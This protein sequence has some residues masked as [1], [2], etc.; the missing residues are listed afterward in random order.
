MVNS[1]T[2]S[3]LYLTGGNDANDKKR[4]GEWCQFRSSAL[5]HMLCRDPAVGRGGGAVA[6]GG[7]DAA[8]QAGPRRPRHPGHSAQ[9]LLQQL[10]RQNSLETHRTNISGLISVSK[11]NLLKFY[12]E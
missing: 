4:R 2:T 5:C 6:A 7:G 3:G 9:P 10:E 1:V 12:S 11:N 8:R